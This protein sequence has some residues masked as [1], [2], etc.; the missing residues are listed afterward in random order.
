MLDRVVYIPRNFTG[1]TVDLGAFAELLLF[2][3]KV[4]V[5]VGP[6]E[7]TELLSSV[8]LDNL[9]HLQDE[10]LVAVRVLREVLAVHHN[11]RTDIYD[12][13]CFQPNSGGREERLQTP[14]E[15]VTAA[16]RR[17]RIGEG[18]VRRRLGRFFRHGSVESVNHRVGHPKGIPEL[19]RRDLEDASY[20]TDVVRA[21]LDGYGYTNRPEDWRFRVQKVEGGFRIDTNLDFDRLSQIS[22]VIHGEPRQLTAAHLVDCVQDIRLEHHRAAVHDADIAASFFSGRLRQLRLLD[23]PAPGKR[24]GT[25]QVAQFQDVVLQGRSIGDAMRSGRRTVK[26]LLDLLAKA[27]RFKEWLAGRPPDA[28]L[29]AEYVREISHL[30]WIEKLPGRVLRF[31]LVSGASLAAGALLDPTAG[32]ISG[33]GLAAANDFLIERLAHGWR[34]N[35]FVRDELERFGR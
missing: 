28:D 30:P 27:H 12:F 10:G 17:A 14:G 18:R 25:E 22:S 20:V 4:E 16:M 1:T 29:L 34:P 31:S 33:V 15:V 11:R 3:G 26:D 23:R 32:A 8:G 21:F 6:G 35:Q 7:F 13:G 19:A 5:L 24:P 2:F 9:L